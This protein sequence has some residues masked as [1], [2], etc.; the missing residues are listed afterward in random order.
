[1]TLTRESFGVDGA[2]EAATASCPSTPCKQQEVDRDWSG[3]ERAELEDRADPLSIPRYG[4][5]DACLAATTNE[6]RN[7]DSRGRLIGTAVYGSFTAQPGSYYRS[8]GRF[9]TIP[10]PGAPEIEVLSPL[11]S[12]LNSQSI[13][14]VFSAP[15]F[16]FKR[17]RAYIREI[18]E[19]VA[20][21]R[22]TVDAEMGHGA[23][24]AV[25]VKADHRRS[26]ASWSRCPYRGIA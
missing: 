15:F 24:S 19:D 2:G 21:H 26:E 9:T 4:K 6:R 11:A 22:P 14:A 17:G 20:Q 3:E 8:V 5:D 25:V 13:R 7:G 10:E 16:Q 18:A 23:S 1:M 12:M